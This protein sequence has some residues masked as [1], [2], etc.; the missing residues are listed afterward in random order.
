MIVKDLVKK[1]TAQ[2]LIALSAIAILLFASCQKDPQVMPSASSVTNLVAGK[3]EASSDTSSISSGIGKNTSAV[4]DSSKTSVSSGASVTNTGNTAA[5]AATTTS[6]TAATSGSSNNSTTTGSS[7]GTTTTKS[8]TTTAPASGTTTSK[9]TTS[10]S[11]GTTTTTSGT[12]KTSATTASSATSTTTSSG[13]T[14]TKPNINTAPSTTTTTTTTGSAS[15]QPT[16]IVSGSTTTTTNTTTTKSTS[17]TTTTA[18][19]IASAYKLAAPIVLKNQSNLTIS[20][21]SINGGAG[22]CISLTNCTNIHITKCKLMNGTTV[23]STGLNLYG[24]KNITIDYCFISKVATGVY[25]QNSST[26]VVDNNQF[27]NMM[28]PYPRGAYVQF[29]N[30]SGGG[31]RIT[32][33]KGENVAGQSNPEDGINLYKSNG[34]STDPILVSG[35][36]LR[37]G[38]P[39]TTGSGI[40][41]G[42]QG[43]SYQTITNN[44]CVNTGNIGMQVAGGTYINMSNNTIYST[45]TSI[46]HLGLGCG[47]YSGTASNNITM[48][49]NKIKWMCGKASDLAYYPAGTT[50]VEKDESVQSGLAK[51]AGWGT[52]ILSATISANILP[53]TLID[54][55]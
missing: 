5:P 25:A 17:A 44:T 39:S 19:K 41:V 53:T 31:N 12:T 3:T 28:G 45:A 1:K 10:G 46:S 52:N 11:T 22:P 26:V 34:L 13:T 55:K 4:A 18:P 33:N 23:S 24:C 43:G 49:G 14:A 42:D 2:P 20:G 27:L 29:N 6:G 50:V 15:S 35:N 38:G 9:T 54:F 37:G 48:G 47:N 32:N 30:V 8:T 40:T 36:E 16:T 21:D 51:P 7:A